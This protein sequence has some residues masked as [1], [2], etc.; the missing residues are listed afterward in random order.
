M[1]HTFESNV[2]RSL[3]KGAR[4]ARAPWVAYFEWKADGV[5]I[6][7]GEYTV[8]ELERLT[9]ELRPTDPNFGQF[10]AALDE[11]KNAVRA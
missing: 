11:L 9:R 3:R 2:R 4:M 5:L 6:E 8:S 10:I 7:S 1:R